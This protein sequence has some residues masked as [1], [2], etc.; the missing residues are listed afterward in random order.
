MT[1]PFSGEIT[2][3]AIAA[4]FGNAANLFSNYSGSLTVAE[5]AAHPGVPSSGD[6]AITDF[7][8]TVAPSSGPGLFV[9]NHN[10]LAKTY[11]T[12]GSITDAA[13]DTV[14][15]KTFQGWNVMLGQHISGLFNTPG[16]NY[17]SPEDTT[18]P[19]N[20]LNVTGYNLANVQGPF[21]DTNTDHSG[22]ANRT[23]VPS[24]TTSFV[25]PDTLIGSTPS[26]YNAVLMES[27]VYAEVGYDVVRGPVLYSNA[28]RT[29]A[30]GEKVAFKY[31]VK[32]GGDAY[33]IFAY[34]VD[35]SNGTQKILL[36]E[37]QTTA[38]GETAWR[39]N[40]TIVNTTGDYIFVF[41]NG[42]YD[43]TGFRLV[44]ASLYVTDIEILVGGGIGS[45][46]NLTAGSTVGW[47]AGTHTNVTFS[48]D[49][50]GT[51]AV[52]NVVLDLVT[53]AAVYIIHPGEG[54]AVGDTITVNADQLGNGG[55]SNLTFDV[56]NIG[57]GVGSFNNFTPNGGSNN[58]WQAGTHTNVTFSTDGSNLTGQ[59]Y[60][61]GTGAVFNILVQSTGQAVVYIIDKGEGYAVGD[62]IT[63][64]DDQLGNNGGSNLTFDVATLD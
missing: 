58:T 60:R 36:N 8:T 61:Y 51:G 41:V 37:T 47:Q 55:G 35:T 23:G 48:T 20:N 5:R 62:T 11:G 52:F 14:V 6:I 4:E 46:D 3:N 30:A 9:E 53:T 21:K 31:K 40:E 45:V 49:G 17:L 57:G 42:S 26:G 59:G 27:Y 25:D 56:A 16:T 15:V 10:M 7:Y 19:A 29:I 63:V 43:F 18:Y 64:N 12:D 34:M 44:G 32:S 24:Y 28:S 54:Y 50:N 33:D 1:L 2:L 22:N 39:S 38:G 13:G